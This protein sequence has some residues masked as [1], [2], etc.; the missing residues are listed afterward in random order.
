MAWE[1]RS[2]AF[3]KTFRMFRGEQ[4]WQKIV[5]ENFFVEKVLPGSILRKLKDEELEWYHAPFKDKA[6]TAKASRSTSAR[7]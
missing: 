2:E 1:D 7:R 5:E 6:A 4:G 3:Q